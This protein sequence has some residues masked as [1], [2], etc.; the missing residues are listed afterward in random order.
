MVRRREQSRA[1]LPGALLWAAGATFADADGVTAY[2]PLNL[3]PEMER[4]IERVLILADEPILRRPFAVKLVKNALPA[5]CRVDAVLCH[6]VERYLERYS[7]NY[8][9]TA[10]S[11]TGT[12]TL[13]KDTTGIVP[14]EYGMPVDSK[15]EL[16]A[17]GY[18]QAN[19]YLLASVGG[20]A[21]SGR[22]VP[23]GSMLSLG[24]RYAQLD[25]GYRNHWWSPMTDSSSLMSTEAPTLPSA[26]LSN[27]EPLTRLGLQY[28]LFLARMTKN[29]IAY[30]GKEATG[31]PRLFGLEVSIEPFPGWS[32]GVNRLLQYGGGAGLPDS[33]R[34]LLRDFFR[35]GGQS[36]NQG[37]QEASYVSRFIFPGRVPFAVYFQYAGENT[38]DGGSYLLGNAAMSAGIDFPKIGK[39]FDLTYEFS[40]WQNTWYANFIF[41]NGM[42]TDGIVD[43]NWGAAEREPNGGAG[44]RSQMLRVGW[45]PSFGGYLEERVRTLVNQEYYA[46]AEQRTY[47]PGVPYPYHHYI[48]FTLRYSRPWNSAVI[49]GELLTGQDVY[50]QRFSRLSAFVRYGGDA[51]TRQDDSSPEADNPVGDETRTASGVHGLESFVDVGINASIVHANLQQREP[52]QSTKTGIDPHVALGARR[53]VSASNDLGVRVE[54]DEVHGHDLISARALDYRYRFDIPLAVG[55]FVGAAR[56]DLATPAYSI[57]YGGGVQWRDVLPHWDISL[58]YRH[59][60]NLARDHLLP[61]DPPGPRPDSFYKIDGE[62][63]FVSRRF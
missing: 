9:V 31:N 7:R 4:Q 28:E 6:R 25:I 11:A 34:F 48:D 38:E 23:V 30:D 32:V 12:L 62:I 54:F 26:T 17:Q 57:Y 35:P 1:L 63:L 36:Q 2:L 53:A 20:V 49:G 61:S 33:T 37:N 29:L 46:I 15:W 50:G 16:S 51:R 60:Q 39:F 40:E 19:D 10:A 52:I 21:Y 41:L 27:D 45:E 59:D 22:T 8:A 47:S 24:D 5:A 14:N 43:G 56:Y 58:E 13:G 3:E 55:L 44:A 18:V 42:T